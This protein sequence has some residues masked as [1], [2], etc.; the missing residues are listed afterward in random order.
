MEQERKANSDIRKDLKEAQSLLE[1]WKNGTNLKEPKPADPMP[2]EPKKS[3]LTMNDKSG[4]KVPVVVVCACG[5]QHWA[6]PKKGNCVECKEP[7]PAE[8]K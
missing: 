7:L 6:Y 8:D 5:K 4:K 3:V 1:A 2:E